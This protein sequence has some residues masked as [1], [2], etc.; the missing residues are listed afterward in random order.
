MLGQVGLVHI[1]PT[2]PPTNKLLIWIIPDAQGN[3]VA[4]KDYTRGYWHPIAQVEVIDHFNSTSKT[5]AAS[6]RTVMHLWGLISDLTENIDDIDDSLSDF[7]LLSMANQAGG[8]PKIDPATGKIDS[9]FINVSGFK[10]QGRWD[11][12]TGDPPSLNPSPGEIW[13]VGTPGNTL[14]D[15]HSAWAKG[16]FVYRS[17]N[18]TYEHLPGFNMVIYDGL[19]Q[20]VAGLALDARQGK[21]LKDLIDA[22]TITVNNLSALYTS[23]E[24][25]MDVAEEEIQDLQ[26]LK[27]DKCLF[28]NGLVSGNEFDSSKLGDLDVD[29]ML[30]WVNGVLQIGKMR[31]KAI[32]DTTIYFPT[33]IH[34]GKPIQ[35]L[36]IP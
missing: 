18:N 28:I 25:R 13:S 22:L 12:S 2:D 27:Q 23:L 35:I 36:M 33:T 16:D 24:G 6:A 30:I 32:P 20:A 3:P 9:A 29:S 4:F 21:I 5:K 15:G 17:E 10:P 8:Y 34:D 31:T 26:D 14:L 19:D 1:H 7:V 11:A